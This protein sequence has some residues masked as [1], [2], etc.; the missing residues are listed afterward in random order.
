MLAAAILT[1]VLRSTPR[2]QKPLLAR[3]PVWGLVDVLIEFSAP[4]SSSLRQSF[5]NQIR[6]VFVCLF[7]MRSTFSVRSF[8][9]FSWCGFRTTEVQF[10]FRFSKIAATP[11]DLWCHNYHFLH[12]AWVVAPMLQISSQSDE[13]LR[14]KT[15]KFC[16]DKQT[17]WQTNR[18]TNKQTRMRYP[19]Q[20]RG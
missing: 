12:S 20:R 7:P 11:H 15:R 4:V 9:F 18:Q 14:R 13:R 16:A 5:L 6:R 19:R 1:T 8:K 3:L 17:D 2:L 10:F